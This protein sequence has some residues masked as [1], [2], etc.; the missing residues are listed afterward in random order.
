[1]VRTDPSRKY[2]DV[3]LS[4]PVELNTIT[5]TRPYTG[6]AHQQKF[7][8]R[9]ISELCDRLEEEFNAGEAFE[10]G[11][12][13]PTSN[14]WGW[15]HITS[16]SPATRLLQCPW[17]LGTSAFPP[18]VTRLLHGIPMAGRLAGASTQPAERREHPGLH[19]NRASGAMR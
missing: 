9:A 11:V 12:V 7:I 3:L 15:S 2:A 6:I 10:P 8:R 16:L 17:D 1:M 14:T 4:L 13:N 18:V 19:P 5:W